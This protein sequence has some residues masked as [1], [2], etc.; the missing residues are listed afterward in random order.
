MILSDYKHITSHS[1]KVEQGSVFFSFDNNTDNI[2]EAIINKASLIVSTIDLN[3]TTSN[4]VVKNIKYFFSYWYKQINQID[5]NK[6]TIIGITGTDGKTTTAK[7]IYDTI[8]EKYKAIYIGT[9]GIISSDYELET[10][11]TTPDIE[12]ILETFKYAKENKI[13]YIIIECSSEGLMNNRLTGIKV[14]T[15]F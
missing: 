6:F 4:L 9:L 14:W 3:L 5:L 11:N 1:K 10:K 15:E 12:T 2:K 8:T 7:M 13:K